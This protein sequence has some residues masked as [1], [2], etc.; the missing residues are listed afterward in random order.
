MRGVPKLT[1]IRYVEHLF[2]ISGSKPEKDVGAGRAALIA[3]DNNFPPFSSF[4]I[5]GSC[6]LV[7]AVWV[8]PM[9]R[10]GVLQDCI[11]DDLDKRKL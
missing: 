4:E 10:L 1:I 7:T 2:S 8:Q 11:D 9:G 3:L 5:S 6:F